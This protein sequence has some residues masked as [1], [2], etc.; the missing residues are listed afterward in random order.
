[1]V[2][3]AG[4]VLHA[5]RE[6]DRRGRCGDHFGGGLDHGRATANQPPSVALTA[7]A[8][9]ATY[10]APATITLTATASDP[11]NRLTRVEFYR[12]STLLGDG[13]R[14]AVGFTWSSV[15][16]GSY[17]LTAK[18]IDADGAATTS[19]AVSI[20]VEPPPNQPPSV[21]LTAPA[22]GATYTAPATI[23][24]TAT[25]SDPENRLTRVEFY[26]E[27]TLLGSDMSAPFSF[28]W[29]SVPA[30]SYTLTAKAIDADGGAT[31]SAAASVT[32][33]AATSATGVTFTASA[34]HDTNVTSYLLE[35]FANG[36]DPNTGGATA[37][38]DLGKP[39][40]TGNAQ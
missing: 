14:R 21:A 29:S 32:V 10:T 6:S 16:V 23:T 22:S 34:D 15:Q 33:N 30:G 3:S 5:D 28:T 2:F 26:R 20:T 18:A 27:S 1:M 9:G 25:A 4:G 39:A 8:S 36:T 40:A 11:E 35:V 37:S 24:L 13:T 17:T 19:A 7:P 38:S 12:G 31:T